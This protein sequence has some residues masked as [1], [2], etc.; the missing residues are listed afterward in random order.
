MVALEDR[1][2]LQE[3]E[4][5]MNSSFKTSKPVMTPMSGAE[6]LA[7]LDKAEDSIVAG[8]WIDQNDLEQESEKW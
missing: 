3:I 6:Y 7:M 5:L 1:N 2:I 8:D 4:R